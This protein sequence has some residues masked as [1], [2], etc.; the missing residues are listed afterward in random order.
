MGSLWERE[1]FIDM[2]S[3]EDLWE[4]VA[5]DEAKTPLEVEVQGAVRG[6]ARGSAQGG[7]V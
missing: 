1:E 4:A 3:K 7:R 2:C 5:E 6:G